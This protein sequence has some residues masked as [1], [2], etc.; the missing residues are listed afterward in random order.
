[1][2]INYSLTFSKIET[3]KVKKEN[4]LIYDNTI[5]KYFIKIS[6]S[7]IGQDKSKLQ[8]QISNVLHLFN[9]FSGYGFLF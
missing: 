8:K 4:Y 2:F 9:L 5:Y 7:S 1:M 6:F 3:S